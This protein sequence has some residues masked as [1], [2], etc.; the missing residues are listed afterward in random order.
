MEEELN[1]EPEANICAREKAID[2]Q[3]FVM[4]MRWSHMCFTLIIRYYYRNVKYITKMPNA[5][6]VLCGNRD[7]LVSYY[8]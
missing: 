4:R 2:S 8:T 3:M 5:Y 7:K 6:C 1:V